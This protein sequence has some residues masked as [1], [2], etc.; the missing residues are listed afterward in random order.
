[1]NDQPKIRIRNAK[2][3]DLNSII[4]VENSAFPPE[5]QAT[6]ETFANRLA[7]NEKGFLV[8]EYEG[9]IVAFSTAFLTNNIT[10]IKDFDIPDEQL[11]NPKGII[12][13]LRSIAVKKDYQKKGFGKLLLFKQLENATILKKKFFR[14]TAASDVARFYEKMGFRRISPYHN[15]HNSKQAIWEKKL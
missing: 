13:E 10:N 2:H 8:L 4:E 11:H 3:S 1:M 14:F 7:L 5:R 15:F 12:F 6:I 9:Q